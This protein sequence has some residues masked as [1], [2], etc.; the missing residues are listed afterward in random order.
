MSDIFVIVDSPVKG[1]I[2]SD[3]FA[4]QAE[5]LVCQAPPV[6]PVHKTIGG[7]NPRINFTFRELPAGREIIA[8][9]KQNLGKEIYL[10]LDADPR[11]EYFAWLLSSYIG[12]LAKTRILVKRLRPIGLTSREID[13]SLR[14]VSAVD[15]R[16]G[17][18]F[19]TRALFEGC[20]ARHLTRLIGT[21]NGPANLPLNF[22]TLSTI[23]FLADREV[24]IKMIAP[25]VKWQVVADLRLDG[26]IFSARL[27]EVADLTT[28]GFFKEAGDALKAVELVRDEKFSVDRV[29]REDL[30]IQPP[31]P[32]KMV[33]LLHDAFVL[34]GK[35]LKETLSAL[36]KLFHGTFI[37]G[38]AV[39]LIST[40]YA[41]ENNYGT[42]WLERLRKQ[43]VVMYGEE[44]LGEGLSP[45]ISNAG[46]VF[47]LRPEMSGTDLDE[48]L[49][50]GEIEIYDLLRRRA[51]ASQMKPVTGGN[52][53]VE[54]VA[55]PESLFVTKFHNVSAPGFMDIYQGRIGKD[56]T[57]PCPFA[58]ISEGAEPAMLKLDTVQ[59]GTPPA[60][61]TIETLF[62][63]LA[64]FAIPVDAVNILMIQEMI[65]AGYVNL[66]KEGYLRPGEKNT[67]V[68]TILKRT[69]PRMQ[70][71]N[72][73]AYIE[74]TIA[75][76]IS[77]RKG[78][79]FALK[80]F[81]QTLMM[82]GKSMVKAKVPVQLRP[83][84]RIS[85]SIIKQPGDEALSEAAAPESAVEQREQ[86]PEAPEIRD[87]E[88]G[89][90]PPEEL[91]GGVLI[92][93]DEKAD[94]VKPTSRQ[95]DSQDVT[96]GFESAEESSETTE[97][98]SA[99]VEE[100]PQPTSPPAPGIQ[101][102]LEDG[103]PPPDAGWSDE[104][105]KIFAQA[106]EAGAE[107]VVQPEAGTADEEIID[108]G[109]SKQCQV[110]GQPMLLK[111]DRFGK[112]WSCSTFPKCRHSEAYS[113][114]DA[115]EMFCPLCKEGKIIKK[116]TPTGKSFYVC[117][118]TD[119]EFMAWS[120]PY[121]IPCQVC[122]SS[123][124]VEKKALDGTIRLTCPRAGC[125]YSL[126][127]PGGGDPTISPEPQAP[128]K[129]IRVRR[130]S[131]GSASG[132][133]KKI[134]RVVRRKK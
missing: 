119:C 101:A 4:G 16:Q 129:K 120:R 126:S 11:S 62:A 13:E 91:E 56:F 122:D 105:Q 27:E 85:R 93:A 55:G 28:D 117:P 76:V 115:Q 49:T 21:R 73:S 103:S 1:K 82:H 24:E 19:Y 107:A 110:C 2:F 97:P 60:A 121:Y 12:Q 83:R 10:A 130:V 8:K 134:V 59:G 34:F 14:L 109:Q 5:V 79:D 81:D 65:D 90:L 108:T 58:G 88:Q 41:F 95:I 72:L 52:I 78:L 15:E 77:G 35:P 29:D 63:D 23:F 70:G 44:A 100:T 111:K 87:K 9:I 46:M 68:D 26:H 125:D 33:E 30:V 38:Q 20:L 113:D 131:K 51:L 98:D 94:E 61:Y 17:I 86:E 114:S 45:S 32:Y 116:R 53:K 69:F 132:S 18:N 66:T 39:G 102:D 71:I 64:D 75:E 84:K 67:Q 123:Y 127:L 92:P 118:E 50:P 48:E 54:I 43:V 31:A 22:N 133:G 124:L 37:D 128:K 57:A 40:F 7:D 25:S 106:M 80:Q 104:L 42:D 3:Y 36:H 47:P 99:V 74:Q 6:K 112:F 96:A 89:N